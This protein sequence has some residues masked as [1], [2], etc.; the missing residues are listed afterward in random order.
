MK[1]GNPKNKAHN[2]IRWILSLGTLLYVGIRI[3]SVLIAK[4]DYYF[5]PY[6]TESVYKH[7][8]DTFNRS[9]YR[10][11]N[12]TALIPDETVFSYAAGAYLHGIDPILI[13]SEHTPLGKYLIALFIVLI[14]NDRF[15]VI[16]FSLLTLFSL[17]YLGFHVLHDKLLALIPVALFSSERLFLDQIRYAPL[18]DIIQLPFIFFTLT[19]FIKEYPYKKFFA[20]SLMIGTVMATKTIIP[21]VLLTL[22]FFCVFILRKA[23]NSLFYFL[24]W[25]PISTVILLLTYTKTF[26]SGYTIFDFI[27]FQKWILLYQKSKLIFPFSVWR[28]IFLNQWQAWW[29]DMRILKADDWSITWPIV[30]LLTISSVFFVN[31]KV[32]LSKEYHV[33]IFWVIIYSAFLSIGVV[34]SRFFLP[35]LPVLY[36]ISTLCVKSILTRW[37]RT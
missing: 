14:K 30:T 1:H 13:N 28:L 8:E 11:K 7:L 12:P 29:G 17:W 33:V 25:L 3:G 23:W 6:Y 15:I 35:F 22:S 18:L 24:L 20:S 26:L 5:S 21:A 27:G 19:L 16:P 32:Q 31:K 2:P 9:Q 4:P 34:S 36:I 37:A 10:Q